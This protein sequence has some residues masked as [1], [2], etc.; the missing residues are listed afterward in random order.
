MSQKQKTIKKQDTESLAD[1]ISR[2]AQDAR[3]LTFDA[4]CERMGDE[5]T[6][7][8]V[9]CYEAVTALQASLNRELTRIAG[10]RWLLGSDQ[11]AAFVGGR[12]MFACRFQQQ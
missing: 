6:E 9:D 4:D 8:L 1:L 2:A 10:G 7:A 5:N 3:Q 12:L 11:E